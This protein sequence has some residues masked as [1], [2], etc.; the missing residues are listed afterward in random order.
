LNDKKIQIIKKLIIMKNVFFMYIL[1]SLAILSNHVN[2]QMMINLNK[3]KEENSSL[4][5]PKQGENRIVFMGNS[6]TE[7]WKSLSPNFFLDNNY[8]NRGIGGETSTQM[9]LRFRSD[10]INLKPSAVVILAGIND[11]AENQGPISIPDIARN[12]F[13]MSQ[14]ASENNIKVI[15]CS[16]LPAYDFPWRP[17]L[18]PKDKVISLNDLIQKHA[19]EKSFEYV[20]YF[21]SMVDERKGLIKEYGN[22]E[23]HPNLEGYRVMESIIQKSIN[24][25]LNK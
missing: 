24:K 9:L 20:D 21:S 17:G 22:D 10:V 12:I 14:L 23:V 5:L 4:G 6:I 8:V 1:T 19:Q 25:V 16:V 3:Y 2:A 7:D 11:I 15:L 18:N 13:F